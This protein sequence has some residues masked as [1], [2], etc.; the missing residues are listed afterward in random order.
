MSGDNENNHN[1]NTIRIIRIHAREKYRIYHQRYHVALMN[2]IIIIIN[3]NKFLRR[4]KAYSQQISI[5][6]ASQCSEPELEETTPCACGCLGHVQDIALQ[7]CRR[8]EKTLNL[9]LSRLSAQTLLPLNI[10]NV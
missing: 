10:H 5:T 1:N 6:K 9:V 2:I 4:F 8:Q 7:L 3:L